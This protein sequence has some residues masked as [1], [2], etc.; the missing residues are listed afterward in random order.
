MD[1][2]RVIYE[3]IVDLSVHDVEKSQE[4]KTYIM[5]AEEAWLE[6]LVEG[7]T[8]K[9]KS[10]DTA[11]VW[12]KD[13][14]Q[15]I[16][17]AAAQCSADLIVKVANIEAGIDAV[18]HTPQDWNL[19]RHSDVPVML[20]KPNAWVDDP[21][22]LAAVDI[23]KEEQD[24]LHKR[25]LKQA[26]NLA[27]IL[28][29]ELHIVCAYPLIEPWAGPSTIGIDF[30]KIKKDV[31]TEI[32]RRIEAM[33]KEV[34][35]NYKYLHVEEGKAAMVIRDLVEKSSTELLVLGTV[36]RTGVKGLVMGN[37][38]EMILHHTNCDV[39]VLR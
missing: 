4:L 29:G 15:G 35:V 2:V 16:I 30:V 17:D 10:I 23:M 20:L 38:S 18:V 33:T 28:D 9:V 21:V 13:E 5:Q 7:I 32:T 31:E 34:D 37:T 39:V 6:E 8:N 22:I 36:G 12:N 3:G 1:L 26:G 27:Q 11:T 19:L 24:D 14:W 25:V